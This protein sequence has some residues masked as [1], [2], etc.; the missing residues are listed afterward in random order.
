MALLINTPFVFAANAFVLVSTLQPFLFFCLD[1]LKFW[2]QPF[3]PPSLKCLLN[4]VDLVQAHSSFS[5]A[6]SPGLCY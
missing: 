5:L 4:N 6:L 2:V 1:P 3:S